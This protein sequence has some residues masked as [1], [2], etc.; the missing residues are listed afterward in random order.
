MPHMVMYLGWDGKPRFQ[1]AQDLDDAIS[2]VEQ[3]KNLDGI[4]NVRI[5]RLEE[6][7]Y[8]FQVK[9]VVDVVATADVKQ[10]VAA[11][12]PADPAPAER[13]ERSDATANQTAREPVGHTNGLSLVGGPQPAPIT[14]ARDGR[15]YPPP[16][17]ASATGPLTGPAAS[18]APRAG[19]QAQ[20]PIMGSSASS[21]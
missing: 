3:M 4:E 19:G 17:T 9:Y 8:Q 10:P 6:V 7:E 5:F 20:S 2:F 14:G 1:Q 15:A 16:R 18:G 12:A 21:F 13:E 11:I